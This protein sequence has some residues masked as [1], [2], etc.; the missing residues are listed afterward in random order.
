MSYPTTLDSL[1]TNIL[2][3]FSSY[4]ATDPLGDVE[5]P[6]AQLHNNLAAA[7]NRTQEELGLNPSG[8]RSTVKARLDSMDVDRVLCSAPGVAPTVGWVAGWRVWGARTLASFRGSAFTAQ[9]GG[10]VVR[11]EVKR[12][13]VSVFTTKPTLDNTETTTVTSTTPHAFDPDQIV[14]ADNDRVDFYVDQVGD[15]TARELEA[16]VQWA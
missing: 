15:G 12:N 7:V 14:F 3:S 9:T 4:G 10:T 16:A 13:G 1:P 11:W 8:T 6:H 5:G 2:N